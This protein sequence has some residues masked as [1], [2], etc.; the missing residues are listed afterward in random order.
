LA[1][2]NRITD[3]ADPTP[4]PGQWRLWI[5]TGGTF[6]DCLAVTPTGDIRRAKVLSSGGIR[7]VVADRPDPTSVVLGSDWDLPDGFFAGARI[8]WLGVEMEGIEVADYLGS[9]CCLKLACRPRE[10]FLPGQGVEIR[11]EVEAPLLAAHW[12]TR[13][14]LRDPLPP[15]AMRLATTRGT[16]A[17]LERTGSPTA[18][19]ITSGFADLLAIGNQQRADLF[20]LHVDKPQPLYEVVVEVEERIDSFGNVLEPL[21]PSSLRRTAQELLDRGISV[22]AV[23]L[24]HSYRNPQHELDLVRFLSDLGF[25]HVS[26]SAQLAPLIKVVPRAETAIV[27]AYLA[28]VIGV[29]LEAVAQSVQPGPLHVLTSAGSLVRAENYLPKDSLLS[30]PAGGVVGAA[31]TALAS[32]WSRSLAFDMGGTSTDVSRYDGEYDYQFET[33]VGDARLLTP[34]LAIE[35]VAAGGGSICHFDGLQL[36]VGPQSAGAVPGPACYGASGPLTLTDVNLLLGR[37]QP[38]SFEIP[39]DPRASKVAARELLDEIETASG[40]RPE[41][42][43][44]LQGL[45]EIANE[46]MAEAVRRI[47]IRQGYRPS[48]YALVAFGGAGGQHACA[49]AEILGIETVL[50]PEDA[51]LLSAVGLGQARIERLAERQI[52]R[53]FGEVVNELPSLMAELAD[54]ARRDVVEE[55]VETNEIELRRQLVHLR[56]EGQEASLAVDFDPPSSLPERFAVAYEDHYGYQPETLRIEVESLRV[57]AGS[58]HRQAAAVATPDR[59]RAAAPTGFQRSHMDGEWLRVPIFDRI[60]LEPGATFQGPGLIFER[61]C[62]TVVHEEWNGRVDGNRCLILGRNPKADLSISPGRSDGDRS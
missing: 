43:E 12:V 9:D 7:G 61:H 1:S 48:D 44:M 40:Q 14:P 58:H 53:P 34:S 24:L 49:L 55:G 50:V 60:S 18:L 38:G 59:W 19:F 41:L 4:E 36:K 26:S 29:Y 3:L 56:I 17:L 30:G 21:E 62:A 11:A 23:A 37:L 15:T 28:E 6:T 54:Q 35:T 47:S 33:R 2:E 25:R 45:L 5:D 42:D 57:M 20:A 32:G 8:G 46:R 10:E 27:N 31:S 13:T 16:N 22:A 39:V 52:L 51:G